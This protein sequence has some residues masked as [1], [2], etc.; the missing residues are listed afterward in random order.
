MSCPDISVL[1]P[2]RNERDRIAPT[3]RAIARARTTEARVEFVVV[4]DSSTDDTVDN[5]MA[6]VPRLL[7]E[8]RIDVRLCTLDERVGTYRCRNQ[9]AKLACADVLFLTDAHV[10][11]STGWDE[12]LLRHIRPR[13]IVAGTVTNS[14]SAFRGY[15]CRLMVP[16]MRT[17]WN[18]EPSAPDT[19]VQVAVCSASAMTRALFK[20]LG[21]YDPGMILYG[22]GEAEFSVR[23]WLSGAEVHCLPSLEVEHEFKPRD[24]FRSFMVRMRPFWVHNCIRFGLLYLS[25]RGCLQLL[26]YYARAFP[27][28]FQQALSLI[29]E[30]D[31]WTRRAALERARTQPFEW[32]VERFGMRNQMGGEII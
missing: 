10:A 19:A 23:A 21:G 30:S 12:E 24:V 14:S 18:P 26:R 3:V 32:F 25:E 16:L 1:I 8:P 9:A 5:L 7:D 27:A 6:E 28:Y 15:G 29:A 11:F 17:S 22:G 31:L 13:R 4:D 2:A 20:E